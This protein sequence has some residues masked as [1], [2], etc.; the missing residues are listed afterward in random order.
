MVEIPVYH[1]RA[2]ADV[3][4]SQGS[5]EGPGELADERAL[6][7]RLE[8]WLAVPSP[9]RGAALLCIDCDRFKHLCEDLSPELQERIARKVGRR[10][11]RYTSGAGDLARTG[12]DRFLLAVGPLEQPTGAFRLAGAI[13]QDFAR[14]V[15]V[16]KIDVHLSVSV[17]VALFP[18]DGIDADALRA[19]AESATWKAKR[20]GG[21]TY[22][23]PESTRR[24]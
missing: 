13:V 23:R 12:S 20:E 16:G 22:A 21:N 8:E 15:S 11:E 5:G 4:V 14:P 2:A 10:L 1:Q 9:G 17:G 19:A 6:R 3:P 24:D 18:E 7:R